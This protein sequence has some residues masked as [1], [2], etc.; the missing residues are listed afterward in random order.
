MTAD[1]PRSGRCPDGG[2]CHGS[3]LADR[4]PCPEGTCYRVR[5][6][7]PLSAARYPGDRWPDEVLRAN[8]MAAPERPAHERLL[9]MGEWLAEDVGRHTCGT[10]PDGHYGAHEPGC[11]IEPVM[12]LAEL[13]ELMTAL[14][15]FGA[16]LNR[17]AEVIAAIEER[18]RERG[19]RPFRELFAGGPD[20]PCRTVYRPEEAGAGVWVNTECVEVPL[21]E[22]RA[23]FTEAGEPE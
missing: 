1:D 10:G 18:G 21:D 19:V 9:I 15:K 16:P 7:A 22:V 3:T 13:D 17:P 6:A 5:F 11:G 8:G 20:T 2:Y 4:E 23:A 14:G 12:T